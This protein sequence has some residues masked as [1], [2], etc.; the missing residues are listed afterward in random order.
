MSKKETIEE[1]A[2]DLLSEITEKLGLIPVDAEFVKEGGEYFLR[3]F[4]D[5]DGGAGVDDCENVS[6]LLDPELDEEN[7]ISDP[8]TLEVSSP[9]LNRILK[10][11]RDFIFAK[12]KEVELHTWKAV[13][14]CREFTGILTDFNEDTISIMDGT[15][16]R[17]FDRTD[18]SL[19]RLAFEF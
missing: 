11:P 4:I 13:G 7:L 5:R 15:E 1:R 10:R 9:G 12:G 19:I 16:I 2:W 14:R 17:T 8:Y 18:I 6:R 3:I